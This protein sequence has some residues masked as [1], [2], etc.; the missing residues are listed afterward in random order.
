MLFSICGWLVIGW[1][2]VQVGAILTAKVGHPNVAVA[3]FAAFTIPLVCACG[4][5]WL[6]GTIAYHIQRQGARMGTASAGVDRLTR[7]APMAR[8]P[9]PVRPSGVSPL[10]PTGSPEVAAPGGRTL[11][12]FDCSVCKDTGKVLAA[13]AVGQPAVEVGCWHCRPTTYAADMRKLG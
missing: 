12:Y 2:A 7:P 6:V 4:L 1:F 13:S 11:P 8:A 5:I 3:A 10:T 9:V